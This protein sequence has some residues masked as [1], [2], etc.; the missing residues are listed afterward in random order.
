[1]CVCV[2]LRK[3]IGR[4]VFLCLYS[5]CRFTDI[6]LVFPV[7]LTYTPHIP[8]KGNMKRDIMWLNQTYNKNVRTNVGKYSFSLYTSTSHKNMTQIIIKK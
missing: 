8:Q 2:R 4:K 5:D 7:T 6:F 1:M 3:N